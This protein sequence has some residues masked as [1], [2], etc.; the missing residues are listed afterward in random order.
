MASERG[1]PADSERSISGR[2]CL[3]VLIA[4]IGIAAVMV[5]SFGAVTVAIIS[6]VQ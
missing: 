2:A 6:V 3:P 1:G 5:G 4:L